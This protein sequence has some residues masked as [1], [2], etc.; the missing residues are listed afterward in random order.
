M[1]N[2]FAIA[3]CG[4]ALCGAIVPGLSGCGGAGATQV[5]DIPFLLTVPLPSEAWTATGLLATNA[6]NA[7]GPGGQIAQTHI[8]ARIDDFRGFFLNYPALNDVFI[9]ANTFAPR[10]LRSRAEGRAP[11]AWNFST[12]TSDFVIELTPRSLNEFDYVIYATG[13]FVGATYN[14]DRV[15]D[16]RLSRVSKQGVG[17]W[18]QS[19]RF[20]LPAA[21]NPD[22]RGRTCVCDDGSREALVVRPIAGTD[23]FAFFINDAAGTDVLFG[24]GEDEQSGTILMDATIDANGQTGEAILYCPQDGEQLLNFNYQAAGTTATGSASPGTACSQ[25]ISQNSPFS[26]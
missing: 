3:I 16:G 1:K 19:F 9:A 24:E 6:A 21:A 18:N 25:S 5:S 2:R 20:F 22:S 7:Q 26:W 15:L 4:L 8:P 14:G 13:E 11:I 12:D 23:F 17:C 10:D